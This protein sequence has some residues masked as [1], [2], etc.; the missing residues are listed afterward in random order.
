MAILVL[1]PWWSKAAAGAGETS[2]APAKMVEAAAQ[3][4]EAR[5]R[6]VR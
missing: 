1:L 5:A 6:A 4:A 2:L 3:A